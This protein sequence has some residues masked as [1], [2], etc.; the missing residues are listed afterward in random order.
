MLG[1]E[2][3]IEGDF[4]GMGSLETDADGEINIV[5]D[6]VQVTREPMDRLKQIVTQVA[7]E[8]IGAMAAG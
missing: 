3:L 8:L 6:I 4:E 1:A 5:D 2:V 7:D